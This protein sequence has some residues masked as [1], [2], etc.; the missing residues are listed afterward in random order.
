MLKKLKKIPVVLGMCLLVLLTNCH[1]NEDDKVPI[2]TQ[3]KEA[4]QYYKKGQYHFDKLRRGEAAEYFRKAIELDPDFAMAHLHLALIAPNTQSFTEHMTDAVALVDKVSQAEKYKILGMQAFFNRQPEKEGEYYQKLV[5]DYPNDE[6]AQLLLGNHFFFQNDYNR[7]LGYYRRAIQLN[8]QFSLAYNQLGYCHRFLENYDEAEE[9]F[10]E[11]INLV[12]EDPNPYDSYGDL[13]IKMGRFEESISMYQKALKQDP[14]FSYSHVGISTN[15]NLLEKHQKARKNLR[16]ALTKNLEQ[17]QQRSLQYAILTSFLDEESNDS[18]LLK[19]REIINLD[20]TWEDTLHLAEDYFRLADILTHLKQYEESLA[21]TE[22]AY[23][24]IKNSYVSAEL[25]HT[26]YISYLFRLTRTMI[27]QRKF[28]KASE[29][30]TELESE[31]PK[32]N[33]RNRTQGYY[34]LLGQL[35]LEKEQYDKALGEFQRSS[36]QNPFNFMYTGKAY[37]KN[38]I[39]TDLRYLGKSFYNI[40]LGNVRSH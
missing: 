10:K 37:E 28:D 22:K 17:Y 6:R 35:A 31:I 25:K 29:Y 5:Q 11:Y 40:F 8:P 15:L 19:M 1:S 30:L 21:N 24:L 2:T 26:T 9:A 32:L 27:K 23:Q 3:S 7:A 20:D 18:S 13:L 4:L 34:G 16:E 36:R 14:D 38:P 12:P 39:L 33:D